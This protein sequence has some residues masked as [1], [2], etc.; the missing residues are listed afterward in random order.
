MGRNLSEI[1]KASWLPLLVTFR[2]IYEMNEEYATEIFTAKDG[3]QFTLLK[4]APDSKYPFSFG[5][6][7]A[8]MIL[9]N[10][11][12]VRAFVQDNDVEQKNW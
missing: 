6:H 8:K 5:L 3:R 4:L 1:K 7:K 11:D 9:E 10:L 2:E 12:Q